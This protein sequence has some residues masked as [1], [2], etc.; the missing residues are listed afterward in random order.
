[1]AICPILAFLRWRGVGLAF[2]LPGASHS[3]HALSP[4]LLRPLGGLGGAAAPLGWAWREA[5]GSRA[6]QKPNP[7]ARPAGTRQAAGSSGLPKRR[8]WGHL[9][10]IGTEKC[11]WK[12]NLIWGS[13]WGAIFFPLVRHFCSTPNLLSL[14][15]YGNCLPR[16]LPLPKDPPHTKTTTLWL[17]SDPQIPGGGQNPQRFCPFEWK[18][19]QHGLPKASLYTLQ[20]GCR[21]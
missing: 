12:S 6:G 15:V 10:L 2:S 3:G 21:E 5:P 20:H 19:G 17:R 13:D 1:M 11:L 7:S 9:G 8:W 18:E 4:P 14:P 16:P